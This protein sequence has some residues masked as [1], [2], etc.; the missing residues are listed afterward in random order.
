MV[1]ARLS[2]IERG[3]SGRFD[4]GTVRII[5]VLL[6]LRLLLGGLTC[7]FFLGCFSRGFLF[8]R[9]SA[10][11]F[12]LSGLP[13]GFFLGGL[14]RGFLFLRLSARRF[15]LGLLL[16]S[17]RFLL[18]GLSLLTVSLLLAVLV[19]LIVPRE[20]VVCDYDFGRRIEIIRC[21]KVGF[22]IY[23]Y[24][25]HLIFFCYP[26]SNEVF[27]SFRLNVGKARLL[28]ASHH[29]PV[30]LALK[31]RR[32]IRWIDFAITGGSRIAARRWDKAENNSDN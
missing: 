32:T 8:L 31:L 18:R 2:L 29:I 10:R 30:G 12:F 21:T 17:L 24:L 14:P 7:R 1:V 5:Y 6:L 16:R 20:G 9:L 11:R 3:S 23:G 13:R 19:V 25:I 26:S 4:C 15:F 27:L 22:S 28:E